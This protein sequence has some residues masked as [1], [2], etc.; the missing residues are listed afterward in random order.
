M[1]ARLFVLD[2]LSAYTIRHVLRLF[3]ARH[4]TVQSPSVL[5]SRMR[6]IRYR[7]KSI[8]FTDV[9]RIPFI[10]SYL[11]E[12]GRTREPL[13]Y[14]S[15]GLSEI[16]F[17]VRSSYHATV[18]IPLT[19]TQKLRFSIRLR[20]PT[21]KICRNSS[22][23]ASLSSFVETGPK[24]GTRTNTSVRSWI[25]AKASYDNVRSHAGSGRRAC[26]QS[27]ENLRGRL[28]VSRAPRVDGKRRPCHRGTRTVL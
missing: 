22:S 25:S 5:A 24:S 10:R 12:G 11:T 23:L 4:P 21:R 13:E 2:R 9:L 3:P 28:D 8:H 26:V 14:S 19:L 15:Y 16:R 1:F 27:A 7:V 17:E 20:M 18:I 6:N